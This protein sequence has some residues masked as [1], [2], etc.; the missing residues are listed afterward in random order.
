M[1]PR[2]FGRV[3]LERIGRGFATH[4]NRTNPYA[5]AL[6][7]GATGA[8]DRP[9]PGSIELVCADAAGY[10]ERQPAGSFAGFTLSN[11]LDGAT[12]GYRARLFAAV[13]RASRPDGVVVLRSFGE[14][15]RPGAD[16]RAARDRSM[17]WGVV[18]A[19]P[20]SALS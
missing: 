12:A 5:R 19:G 6:F 10:L 11:I 7:V 17:L 1:L 3:L 16:N 15:E 9:A 4:P 13:R 2:R 8:P 14:P 18:Q 20:A